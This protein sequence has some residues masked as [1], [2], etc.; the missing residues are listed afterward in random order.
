M[1][2]KKV[3]EA[4]EVNEAISDILKPKSDEELK[5]LSWNFVNG[6]SFNIQIPRKTK[7]EHD[8]ILVS[9]GTNYTKEQFNQLVRNFDPYAKKRALEFMKDT[10]GKSFLSGFIFIGGEWRLPQWNYDGTLTQEYPWKIPNM[11]INPP[12]TKEEIEELPV[13]PVQITRKYRNF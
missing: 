5:K 3:Y 13:F 6:N 8:V 2:A 9:K 10:F 11:F 12:P 1:K 7:S 4:L